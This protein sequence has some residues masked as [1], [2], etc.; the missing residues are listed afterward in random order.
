M[1]H[2]PLIVNE[3]RAPLFVISICICFVLFLQEPVKPMFLLD[4]PG[5][6]LVMFQPAAFQAASASDVYVQSSQSEP[7]SIRGKSSKV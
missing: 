7:G 6:V 2:H 3:S 4:Y 1:I 5:N